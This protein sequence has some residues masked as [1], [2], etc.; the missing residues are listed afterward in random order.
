VATGFAAGDNRCDGV[1]RIP[2]SKPAKKKVMTPA[3]V[4][5]NGVRQ[6]RDYF[7]IASLP[8]AM[9][10]LSLFF[11]M[12]GKV[13]VSPLAVT[14]VIF[15]FVCWL[16]AVGFAVTGIVLMRG[17]SIAGWTTLGIYGAI[18]L[19]RFLTML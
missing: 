8:F 4:L 14:L 16:I 2:A 5:P 10:H 13:I 18:F 1:R 9:I 15:A 6:R 17:R 7:G 3:P 11:A 12:R 19:T